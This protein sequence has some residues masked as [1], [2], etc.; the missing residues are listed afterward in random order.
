MGRKI[1]LMALILALSFSI[2]SARIINVPADYATIQAGIDSSA[3]GDTVLVA[4]G[5][6]YENINF[7]GH[8]IALASHYLSTG[9]TSY[10]RTTTID[11]NRIAAVITIS[12]G[13]SFS[14]ILGF[15]IM[16]GNGSTGGG[17]SSQ[18]SNITIDH[19]IITNNTSPSGGGI[20]AGGDSNTIITYNVISNNR[21][22]DYGGGIYC[23]YNSNV[24]IENNIIEGDSAKEGGGIYCDGSNMIINHNS[25]RNNSAGK[26]GGG[27]SC[28][29]FGQMEINIGSNKIYGNQVYGPPDS[30]YGGGIA[31]YY[32]IFHYFS[33]E[34]Y[35]NSCSGD[36]GG[37]GITSATQIDFENNIIRDNFAGNGGGVA[38]RMPIATIRNNIIFG[39]SAEGIGGGLLA[40]YH[41]VLS[42]ENLIMWNDSAAVN[43]EIDVDS[44]SS[45]AVI[46]N[47]IQGG[48]PGEGNIDID[49]LFGAAP[50]GDF[51]LMAIA[52]GDSA[53]SPCIDA[54]DPDIIDSLLDCS[55]GLGAA[56]SDM[57]AYGGGDS[58]G[59]GMDEPASKLPNQFSLSQN[60]PNPFNPATTISYNLPQTAHVTLE[61]YDILGRKVQTL[62]DKEEIA[63][64]HQAV[65][66]AINKASG[67]YFYRIQAGSISETKR[68]ILLR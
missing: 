43:N 15:T 27:I 6:Y 47:D 45:V 50:N 8:R 23:R 42:I 9:D 57:G 10:V 13:N 56:R 31:L 12:S 62:V 4:P 40:T 52:C 34:V 46:F 68:M 54:G 48:Y 63:G 39:N 20:F 21:V 67:I 58:L 28:Q 30:S 37:I 64:S 61:I 22:V 14:S 26:I 60:Y 53:D 18:S 29:G 32:G 24:K 59:V 16:N 2:A 5:T 38:C 17:I 44:T 66:N 25:I 35:N 65:W 36:G 51:H 11:G 7:N 1:F 55:W 41:S 49:P 33:N 3:N 19:N